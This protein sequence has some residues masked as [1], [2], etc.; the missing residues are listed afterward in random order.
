MQNWLAHREH[1]VVGVTVYSC[2]KDIEKAEPFD[3][4]VIDEASQVRVP[5]SSVA[6]SLVAV[7]PSVLNRPR[8]PPGLSGRAETR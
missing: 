5:E 2:L 8:S 4:V 7:F 3:L 1:A 6:I